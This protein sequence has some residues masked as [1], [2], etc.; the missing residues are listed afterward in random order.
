MQDLEEIIRIGWVTGLQRSR[1]LGKNF[2]GTGNRIGRSYY[3]TIMQKFQRAGLIEDRGGDGWAP[4]VPV[5]EALDA[6]GLAHNAD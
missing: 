3:D 5:D 6:F 4:L 1:W 2:S